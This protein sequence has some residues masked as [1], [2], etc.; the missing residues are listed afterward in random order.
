MLETQLIHA[1]DRASTRLMI[2]LHGLGDSMAG[3]TWVPQALRLPWMN[4]LLVN[5][6][7]LR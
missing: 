7:T 5:A 1:Q 4:Y 6:S 3:Y 2:V